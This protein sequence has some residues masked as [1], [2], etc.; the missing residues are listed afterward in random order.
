M[1]NFGPEVLTVD[2]GGVGMEYLDYRSGNDETIIFMHATGF[3]HWSWHPLAKKLSDK[4]RVISVRMFGHRHAKPE[5][6]MSWTRLGKDLSILCE[7]L[8][9]KKPLIVGHSMGAVVATL[10]CAL[11]GLDAE[12]MM[13]IEPIYLPWF[14]YLMPLKNVKRHPLASK[15]INRKNHWAD[16]NEARQYLLSKPLFTSWDEEMLD[17]YIER[18]MMESEDGRLTLVCPPETEAAMFMGSNRKNPWPLL[19]KISCPVLIVEG[20]KSEN[21]KLVNHKKAANLFQNG[22][23][24]R[25]N[26]AGHLIPMEKPAE[27]IDLIRSFFSD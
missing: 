10:S 19:K 16:K 25:V 8:D 18:G 3:S 12:K 17:I 2:V 6:K 23:V 26:D 9:I 15:S 20:E 11:N 27:I 13:L 7:K 14:I 22:S 4:Y 21:L 5:G 24:H 1:M